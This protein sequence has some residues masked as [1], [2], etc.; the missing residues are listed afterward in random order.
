MPKPRVAII[1]YGMGN[2]FSVNQACQQ[3]GLDS[4]ITDDPRQMEGADA[5]ILPG[6]GAFEDAIATLRRSG[7]ASLLGDWAKSDKP[8]FG[9]CLGFQLLMSESHEFGRHRGLDILPGTVERFD[10]PLIQVGLGDSVQERR[11]KVPHIGWTEVHPAEESGWGGSLLEG[12]NPGEAMYF[13]HSYH[14]IPQDE[15]C[16]LA[17][18]E[19]GQIH[20]CCAAHRGNISAVQFHPERS[21]PPGL[22]IYANFAARLRA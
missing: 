14:V 1:D 18:S 5:L 16:A 15:N 20:F 2:L 12:V 3:V 9:V 7:A 17:T 8:L 4:W 11:L 6:V 21:G 10:S 13:V 22:R 19:Y